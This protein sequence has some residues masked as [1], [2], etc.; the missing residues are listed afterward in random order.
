MV[1]IFY[2]AAI[3]TVLASA[4]A[5]SSKR[6]M[7]ALLYFVISLLA[8]ATVLIIMG[9]Y[10]SAAL[11]VILFIGAVSLL[12]LSVLSITNVRMDNIEQSKRGIS[13]KIW[14]GPLILGFILFVTLVYG[15]AN[16]DYSLLSPKLESE[17]LTDMLLGAYALIIELAILLLLCA[18]VIGYHF[19]YRIYGNKVSKRL[20]HHDEEHNDPTNA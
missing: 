6:A 12:F 18:A 5:I 17:D 11:V 15:I 3:I 7:Q 1:S 13:A 4:K 2:I 14:L 8:T 16:T 19:I 9:A 10:F 20:S